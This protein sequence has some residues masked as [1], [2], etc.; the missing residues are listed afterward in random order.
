M[1]Q[2]RFTEE[3]IIAVLKEHET[4]VKT[5]Y[6]AR[7]HGIGYHLLDTEYAARFP[8]SCFNAQVPARRSSPSLLNP[9][10]ART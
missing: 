7:K 2:A 8:P 10:R 5:A 6:L 4:R 9:A 3:Q 1:K